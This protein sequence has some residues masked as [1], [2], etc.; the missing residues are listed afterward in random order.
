MN[1]W[2]KDITREEEIKPKDLIYILY[3]LHFVIHVAITYLYLCLHW[4][5]YLSPLIHF[6]RC[7]YVLY[8]V[9]LSEVL[10]SLFTIQFCN[11]K[12]QFK[13]RTAKSS[14]I[15][16]NF[17]SC[18]QCFCYSFIPYVTFKYIYIHPVY[19]IK[20]SSYFNSASIT[21]C[22]CKKKVHVF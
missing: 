8:I 7:C 14:W 20:E 10:S 21:F 15:L 19:E 17:C 22:I 9:T 6:H 16:K 18:M 5:H 1:L 11:R 12:S 13:I 2:G 4:R 3:Q